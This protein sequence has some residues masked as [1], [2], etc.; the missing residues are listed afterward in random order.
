MFYFLAVLIGFIIAAMIAVNGG[1]TAS[2]GV[3]FSAVMIHLVGLIVIFI[4]CLFKREPLKPKTKLPFYC[5]LG[6][7]IGVATVFFNNWAFSKISI[8]AILGLSLLGQS[9]TSLIIDHYGFF[10]MSK[11]PFQKKKLIGLAIILIGIVIVMF[12]K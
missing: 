4:V 11:Q 12:V 1:L 2:Y 7:A 8:S 6:G 9:I 3:F 10:G 5:Y